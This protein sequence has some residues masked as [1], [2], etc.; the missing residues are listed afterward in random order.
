MKSIKNMKNAEKEK[1]TKSRKKI[2]IKRTAIVFTV[3]IILAGIFVVC[4]IN[5][6]DSADSSPITVPW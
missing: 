5:D 4:T 2:Y 3:L 6:F 1:K